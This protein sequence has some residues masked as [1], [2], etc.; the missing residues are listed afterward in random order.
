[1]GKNL[2]A[3]RDASCLV[4]QIIDLRKEQGMTQQALAEMMGTKQSSISRLERGDYNPTLEFI[5]KA[6]GALGKRVEIR[7]V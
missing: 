4:R 3:N 1:M 6:A 2:P 5:Q 7:L